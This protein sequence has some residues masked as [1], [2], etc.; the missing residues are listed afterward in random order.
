[1]ELVVYRLASRFFPDYPDPMPAFRFLGGEHGIRQLESALAAPQMTFDGR[2]LHRTIF[3]K[4]AALF[5]SLIINHPLEDGNKRLAL[6]A[7]FIFLHWNNY[8][9]YRPRDEAVAF[10]LRVASANPP[11][12]PEISRWLRQSSLSWA[13]LEHMSAVRRKAHV[14]QFFQNIGVSAQT[15]MHPYLQITDVELENAAAILAELNFK[16]SQ[17]Q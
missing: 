11:H 14:N 16:V 12:L 6:S 2:Y 10:A 13:K 4:A 3:E 8:L 9:L 1:M 5:R 15:G 7:T 17:S